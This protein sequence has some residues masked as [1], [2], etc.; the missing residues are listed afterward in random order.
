MIGKFRVPSREKLS[1]LE[2]SF[3]D[4]G[5]VS[6]MLNVGIQAANG[7]EGWNGPDPTGRRE[8]GGAGE[9]HLRSCCRGM[10]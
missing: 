6:R 10:K 2:R 1:H 3:D 8:T 9:C 5:S 7:D 4:L